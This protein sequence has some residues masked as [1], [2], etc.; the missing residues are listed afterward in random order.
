MTQVLGKGEAIAITDADFARCA[1]A[2]GCHP[3]DLEAIAM[4]ESGGFGWFPDG[5]IKIL[6]EKHWFYKYLEG[7][8]RSSAV[9][10]GL[11]RAAWISPKQGGYNDQ[12]DADDRYALLEKAINVNREGAFKSISMGVYQIMGFNHRTCGHLTAEDMFEAFCTSEA[13]QLSAFVAFLK[14]K[15][16][17]DAI[18]ARDFAKVETGYNG[19]GLKGAYANRMKVESDKLRAG[20]W[21]NYKA[22]MYGHSSKPEPVPP[23]VPIDAPPA[24]NQPAVMSQGP[25]PSGGWLA[26]LLTVIANA[27]TR[28]PL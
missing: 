17:I 21:K 12:A 18:K 24:P 19:G 15:G 25:V 9:K 2:I 22:G 10:A 4:V 14:A 3:A 6:F 1:D 8:T 27:F 5:R 16:L 28:K 23:P 11:A 26:A 20:K 13:Y 7:A